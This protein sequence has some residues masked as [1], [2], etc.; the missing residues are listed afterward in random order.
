[1][2]FTRY[3]LFTGQKEEGGCSEC[4]PDIR[5]RMYVFKFDHLAYYWIG[6][7]PHDYTNHYPSDPFMCL[8]EI[9]NEPKWGFWKSS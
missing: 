2:S 4:G 3:L 9:K 6:K 5:S 8:G 7:Y 1:M